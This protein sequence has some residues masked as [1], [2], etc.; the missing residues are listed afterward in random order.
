MSPPASSTNGEKGVKRAKPE[1]STPTSDRNGGSHAGDGSMKV[2]DFMSLLAKEANI[3][4]MTVE[5]KDGRRISASFKDG[6]PATPDNK[7]VSV[8]YSKVAAGQSSLLANGSG[9]NGTSSLPP[10][11]RAKAGEGSA[12]ASWN[13][14]S[15]LVDAATVAQREHEKVVPG[16]IG[17]SL[18]KKTTKRKPRKIIPEIKEYVEFTQKDVLFGRGG[19]SNRKYFFPPTRFSLHLDHVLT[20][21]S[22]DECCFS[23]SQIIQGTRSIGKLSQISKLTTEA[24]TRTKR[25]ESLRESLTKFKMISEGAFWNWTGTSNAGSLYQTWLPEERLVRLF[26]RTTPRRHELQSGPNIREG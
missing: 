14:M 7:H 17:A 26:V 2:Q 22:F 16:N 24:V 8:T 5:T 3:T 12:E 11:K 9:S 4:N 23:S 18:M 10:K 21:A 1:E 25:L 20:L 6:L 13:A 15:A 19:R